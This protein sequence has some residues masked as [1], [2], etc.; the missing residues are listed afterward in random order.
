MTR[1]VATWIM[2]NI[3]LLRDEFGRVDCDTTF[4]WI[5]IHRF[6]LPAGRFNKATTAVFL[7][8]P[9]EYLNNPDGFEFYID[10]DIKA[11]DGRPMDHIFADCGYNDLFR[12]GYAKCSFHIQTFRADPVTGEGMDLMDVMRSLFYFFANEGGC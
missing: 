12:K 10:K 11:V 6:P 2:A 8:L 4:D 3:L 1:T 5:L 9:G 7:R